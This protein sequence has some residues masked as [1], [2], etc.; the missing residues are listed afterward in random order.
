MTAVVLHYTRQKRGRLF[1]EPTKEMREKGFFAK[2]L[3]GV[4]DP[5][6]IAEAK[7]LYK[8]W[9]VEKE[10]GDRP[11]AYPN[12]TL[13][14]FY[15]RYRNTE[16]W[17]GKAPRTREDYERAWKHIDTWRPERDGPTLSRTTLGR[18]TTECC[19]R[20]AAYLEDEHSPNERH[21][22]IKSLKHL[23]AEAVVRLRLGYASPASKVSNPMPAGRTAIWLAAEV[24]KMAA[25]AHAGGYEA[26]WLM[27]RV[28]WETLLSPV[29][30]WT[31]QVP[32]VKRDATGHYIQRDRT[33]T[34]K[35]AFAA[36]S[37]DLA[38]DLIAHLGG[39][40]IGCA[41]VMRNGEPYTRRRRVN[42]D[43]AAVR[44]LAFGKDEKRQFMDIRRSGNVEADAAG[45]DKADMAKLLANQIDQSK[46][47]EETYT[48]PTVAKAREVAR[49]R[50]EGRQKLA[51]E[52]MRT[53]SNSLAK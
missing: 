1:W 15:D 12:G 23:M 41:F 21:R 10:Q 32:Q 42:E 29:D 33:K 47:L 39:R 48:P 11:T 8:A 44:E 25:A 3:G 51:H 18:I 5:Q 9:L 24:D 7:R 14:G 35:E 19:E 49:L 43:F 22:T 50:V 40:E 27:I 16:K 13:G 45:A 46:F 52:I 30:V 38:R 17:R 6:A 4:D 36:I 34:G 28:G 53:R 26:I 2:P 31:L 37:D 20:F